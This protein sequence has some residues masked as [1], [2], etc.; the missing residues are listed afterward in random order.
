MALHRERHFVGSHSASVVGH[1]DAADASIGQANDDPARSSVDGV[2]N[3]LFQRAGRSFHH[4]TG[5]DT[6]DEMFGQAAY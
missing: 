5:G 1:F 2:L 3:Q 4:F 6:I